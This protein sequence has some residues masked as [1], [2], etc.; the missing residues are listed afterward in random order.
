M[1]GLFGVV[2]KENCLDDLFYG[3]DYHSHL[4]TTIGGLAVLSDRIAEPICHDI[5]NSQFKTEF[6]EDFKKLSGNL[7]IG[8]ISSIEDEYLKL[9][10]EYLK[11]GKIPIKCNVFNLSSFVDPFGN[12][13]PCTIFNRKLGNLRENNYDLKKILLSEKAKK[14]KEE[15]IKDNC[16][17]CWTPCEAHQMIVSN[18]IG[19]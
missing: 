16:P 12:V 18:W 4:G 11:T 6:K 19:F 14:V 10:K 13:Y 7:G 17:Q 2:S 8:V 3:I 15:I 9:G 1:G 5:T